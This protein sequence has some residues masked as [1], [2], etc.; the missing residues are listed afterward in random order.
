M[1]ELM[2]YVDVCIGVE[3]LQLLGEDGT[4]LKDRIA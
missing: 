4:D 2:E 1:A 3:P